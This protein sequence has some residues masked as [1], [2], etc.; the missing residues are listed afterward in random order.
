MQHSHTHSIATSY[1]CGSYE[2]KDELVIT[3]NVCVQL[4]A[5]YGSL[6]AVD[7]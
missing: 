1:G 4:Q 7:N 5:Q 2:N 6:L 3:L